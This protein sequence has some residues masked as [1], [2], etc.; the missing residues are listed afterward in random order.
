MTCAERWTVAQR[1]MV[2]VSRQCELSLSER[3]GGNEKGGEDGLGQCQK[4]KR[5]GGETGPRL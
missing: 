2:T 1:A 5:P 3:I 4:G